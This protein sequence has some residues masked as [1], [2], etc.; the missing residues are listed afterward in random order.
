M[1]G[2]TKRS[3]ATEQVL[4]HVERAKDSPKNIRI[5]NVSA[6]GVFIHPQ[7]QLVSLKVAREEIT[8]AIDIFERTR[9]TR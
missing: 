4:L 2:P 3:D 7:Q 6:D 5:D 8:K 1:A 9:W